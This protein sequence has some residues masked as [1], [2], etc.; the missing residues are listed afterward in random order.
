[1]VSVA[2]MERVGV[3]MRTENGRGGRVAC[4]HEDC[5]APEQ[6]VDSSSGFCWTHD[7]AYAEARRQAS[8]LGGAR[9]ALKHQRQGKGVDPGELGPLNNPADAARW[10]GVVAAAVAAGRI[11]AS[12]ANAIRSLLSEWRSA[13]DAAQLAD[14]VTRLQKQLRGRVR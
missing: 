14:E 6:F 1:V 12:A 10:A 4:R 2:D 11:S 9:T 3:S 13:N 8:A 7:P 5:G